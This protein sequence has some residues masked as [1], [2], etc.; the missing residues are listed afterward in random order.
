MDATASTAWHMTSIPV[1]AVIWAGMVIGRLG[2][3]IA[4]SG[5]MSAATIGYLI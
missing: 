3:R 5:T 1:F 2:S 4:I